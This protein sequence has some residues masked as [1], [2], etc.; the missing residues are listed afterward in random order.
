MEYENSRFEVVLKN[1]RPF[2]RHWH[3]IFDWKGGFE[4]RTIY[5]ARTA[6]PYIKWNWL[7]LELEDEMKEQLRNLLAA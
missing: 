1:G 7:K 6:A 4:D 5:G 3:K 2:L